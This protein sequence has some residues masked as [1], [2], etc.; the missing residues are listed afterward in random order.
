MKAT[1]RNGQWLGDIALMKLG[2]LEGVWAMA[3][4][5][6]LGLTEELRNGQEIEWM[7]EDVADSTV[8]ALYAREG[9]LPATAASEEAVSALLRTPV[10]RAPTHIDV[11]ETE[12]VNTAVRT[13][14]NIF[15]HEFA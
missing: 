11:D 10:K 7:P 4:R 6:G 12:A 5:N 2:H 1:A 14:N 13:F 9:I 15:G 3:L 8:A